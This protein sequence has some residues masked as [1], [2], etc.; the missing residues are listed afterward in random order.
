MSQEDFWPPEP[1]HGRLPR[2]RRAEEGLSP[3]PVCIAGRFRDI[4]WSLLYILQC[5]Q[6]CSA[7]VNQSWQSRA[8]AKDTGHTGLAPGAEDDSPGQ[9]GRKWLEHQSS[10]QQERAA[11]NLGGSRLRGR[12]DSSEDPPSPGS[13]EISAPLAG[14]ASDGDLQPTP[15]ACPRILEARCPQHEI[16]SFFL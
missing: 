7:A 8:C 1:S 13:G 11:G 6:S 2:H 3:A 16:L 15:L 10:H 14:K 4:T 9:G 5:Q 12:R